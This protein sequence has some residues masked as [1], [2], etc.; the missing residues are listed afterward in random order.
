MPESKTHKQGARRGRPRSE[1]SRQAIL[2]ATS[3]LLLEEG[4]SSISMDAVA[5]RAGTSK[6]TIYRWWPSKE[7]LALEVL[8]NEWEPPHPDGHDTGTLTD[9]L[10]ELLLPW[11]RQLGE[12]P[13]GR[14]LAALITR[15]QSDPQFAEEYRARFVQ[16][17]REL[18]GG[19]LARA[20]DRGE[21][22]A[23][24]DQEV[25]LDLLYAPFYHRLLHGHGP[26]TEH[27]AR[28]VVDHVVAS[29][30]TTGRESSPS[31]TRPSTAGSP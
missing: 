19:I 26:L 12:K 18:A 6:A 5:E 3:A 28:A 27:F 1:K 15:A 22:S 11:A 8:F 14:V 9:D 31:G 7:M 4:L 13:Y 25:V 24:A 21:L 30:A 2:R 10:L 23:D 16:P 20:V 29:C 17:R